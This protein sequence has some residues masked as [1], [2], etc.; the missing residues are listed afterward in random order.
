MAGHAFLFALGQQQSDIQK[1]LT[2]HKQRPSVDKRRTVAQA[3][4]N[5]YY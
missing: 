1:Y 2:M 5:A 4:L 3:L